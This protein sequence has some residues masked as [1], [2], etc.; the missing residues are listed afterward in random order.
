MNNNNV[1]N[2]KNGIGIN[3][4]KT[5]MTALIVKLINGTFKLCFQLFMH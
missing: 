2:N 4:I 3:S 1:N 5:S